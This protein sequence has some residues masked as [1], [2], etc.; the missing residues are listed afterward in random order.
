MKA[1]NAKAVITDRLKA[2]MGTLKQGTTA[3]RV[4]AVKRSCEKAVSCAIDEC[5]MPKLGFEVT[6]DGRTV[7]VCV[8]TKPPAPEINIRATLGD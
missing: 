6:L 4:H 5:E 3:R 8:K 1:N 2:C 7:V